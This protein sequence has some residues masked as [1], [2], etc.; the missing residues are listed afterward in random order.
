MTDHQLEA[1]LDA[2]EQRADA[3]VKAAA[4]ALGEVKR[5]KSAAA[6]GQLRALRQ[7]L[8]DVV[9]L[10]DAASATAR[11]LR[12]GWTFDEQA[13]FASGA[14]TKEVLAAGRRAGPRRL[15]VRRPDP[16]LSGDRGRCRRRTPRC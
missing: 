12:D 14:Y 11:D 7:S 3:A 5:A 6:T 15:R 4:A 2:I 16:Q 10:A 9:R 8:D 13:H 1:A